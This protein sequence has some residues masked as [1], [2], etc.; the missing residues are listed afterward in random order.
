M[1][2]FTHASSGRNRPLCRPVRLIT[3]SDRIGPLG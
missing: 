2:M 1:F 3:A